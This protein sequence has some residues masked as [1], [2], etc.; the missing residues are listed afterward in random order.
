[1]IVTLF[2]VAKD[3]VC[4]T[5]SYVPPA[6]TN[7]L[8]HLKRSKSLENVIPEFHSHEIYYN[9]INHGR[10]ASNPAS[11]NNNGAVVNSSNPSPLVESNLTKHGS[12]KAPSSIRSNTKMSHNSA[13]SLQPISDDPSQ[14]MD[15]ITRISTSLIDT[16]PESS[17]VFNRSLERFAQLSE[18]MLQLVQTQNTRGPV[19][20]RIA[21]SK[22][23]EKIGYFRNLVTKNYSNPSDD[24]TSLLEVSINGISKS[25]RDLYGKMYAN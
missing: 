14:I 21:I 18:K 22:L 15:E 16:V 24:Y 5:Q 6:H 11:L 12:V 7:S 17:S 3:D 1:M 25:C 9:L 20:T 8:S 4:K 10:A 13:D 23:R 19:S 2:S